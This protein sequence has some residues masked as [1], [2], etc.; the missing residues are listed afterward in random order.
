MFT[1][2][3]TNVYI[4]EDLR[5][6]SKQINMVKKIENVDVY[7]PNGGKIYAQKDFVDASTGEQITATVIFHD[8]VPNSP[9]NKNF[10]MIFYGHLIDILND[11]GKKIA[12]LSYI[13]E[14]R[15][16]HNNL[17]V[18]TV[19]EIAN[20]LNMSTRTVND[21]LVLLQDKGLIKR[22]TGVIYI[23]SDLICDGRYQRNIM[24]V[25]RSLGEE[26][27]EQRNAR[28]QREI[29]R[30]Q[31]ELESLKGMIVEVQPENQTELQF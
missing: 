23:D 30:K 18:R 28:L 10:E 24:H 22:K 26:T 31:V 15:D 20:D 27:P 14:N 8:D 19:R 25:Y 4:C 2:T 9:N 6:N 1:L 21:T 29:K 16:K 5:N 11:L 7:A 3:K 12:V 17:L 13:I